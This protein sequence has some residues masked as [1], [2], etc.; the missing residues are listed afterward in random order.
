[1]CGQKLGRA[2]RSERGSSKWSSGA[3]ASADRAGLTNAR[4]THYFA[5]IGVMNG[6]LM[7]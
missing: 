5:F 6:L 1:M 2:V 4:N 7:L 3:G